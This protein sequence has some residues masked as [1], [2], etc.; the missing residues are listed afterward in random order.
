MNLPTAP[1]AHLI[2]RIYPDCRY[3]GTGRGDLSRYHQGSLVHMLAP[4]TGVTPRTLQR[5]ITCQFGKCRE[6]TIDAVCCALGVHPMEVY[7][8]EWI[9]KRCAKCGKV[10]K[11]EDF[12]KR[13]DGY[14]EYCRK[15]AGRKN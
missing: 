6:S 9:T 15:C 14:L 8:D 7:G 5:I 13:S 4:L 11:I 1:L 2:E 10:R 3:Q 12:R